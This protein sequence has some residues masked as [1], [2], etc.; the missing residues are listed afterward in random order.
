VGR[1]INWL[2]SRL[3][4]EIVGVTRN[5]RYDGPDK[6]TGPFYYLPGEDTDRRSFYVRT[7]QPPEAMLATVRRV[8]AGQ[9]PDVPIDRLSTMED[10]FDSTIGNRS[11]IAALAGFFGLLA[12]LVAGVGLYGVMAYTVVRRT[13]EIGIRIALG[14]ARRDVLAMVIREVAVVI[15]IGLALGLSSG[16]ALTPLVRSQLY[17]VSPMDPWSI[18]VAAGAVAA[19]ALLAAS[20]PARRAARIEP[21]RALRWE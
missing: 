10:L 7:S 20:L 15:A 2:Q 18:V 11:R 6:P 13:R 1:H 19:I 14:A 21:M 5:Q 12:T 17:N 3:Q 8:V 4:F 9:A 16:L